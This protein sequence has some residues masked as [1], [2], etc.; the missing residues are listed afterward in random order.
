MCLQQLLVQMLTRCR[1]LDLK[2][3]MI[4]AMMIVNWLNMIEVEAF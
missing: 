1:H 3:N 2:G 4:K